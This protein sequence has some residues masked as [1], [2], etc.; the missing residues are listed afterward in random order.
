VS[1]AR[2]GWV[3]YDTVSLMRRAPRTAPVAYTICQVPIS[4]MSR[5]FTRQHLEALLFRAQKLAR[6]VQLRNTHRP[7]LI[8]LASIIL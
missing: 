8:L 7:S 6:A 2:V 1:P 3:S 4:L 5:Q